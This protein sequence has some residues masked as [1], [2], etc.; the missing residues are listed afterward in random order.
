MK[1][2][3]KSGTPL[4]VSVSN[5]CGKQGA[6]R[7]KPKLVYLP[8]VSSFTN[9]T[10]IAGYSAAE[11]GF[12]ATKRTTKR[13]VKVHTHDNVSHAAQRHFPLLYV[14]AKPHS[15]E[16][17]AGRACAYGAWPTALELII[18][19]IGKTHWSVSVQR[20]RG[21]L[22]NMIPPWRVLITNLTSR[23]R[24]QASSPY[25]TLWAEWQ[26]RIWP[27]ICIAIR[28]LNRKSPRLTWV[29]SC[30]RCTPCWSSSRI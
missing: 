28:R 13:F 8:Q 19:D 7:A 12:V 15:A 2:P 3:K 24:S 23:L 4:R 29:G 25:Q 27:P 5:R 10:G 16:G 20:A 22:A 18:P 1:R 9:A 17:R 14:D 6:W 11:A 30:V 26:Y 21:S